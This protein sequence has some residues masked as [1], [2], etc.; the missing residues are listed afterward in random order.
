MFESAIFAKKKLKYTCTKQNY[1][2]VFWN[3]KGV[4]FVQF[5]FTFLTENKM[6]RIKRREISTI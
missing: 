6:V 2:N 3:P 1:D 4:D 5:I